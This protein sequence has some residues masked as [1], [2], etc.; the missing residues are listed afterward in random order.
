MS[1]EQKN[2]VRKT[3][4]AAAAVATITLFPAL[5]PKTDAV[6][7]R[8]RL[9]PYSR[10]AIR[11]LVNKCDARMENIL[12]TEEAFEKLK[13]LGRPAVPLLIEE[14]PLGQHPHSCAAEVIGKVGVN[15]AQMKK[16]IKMLDSDDPSERTGA[17]DALRALYEANPRDRRLTKAPQVLTQVLLY[18][19]VNE[20]GA[21]QEST[22]KAISAIG[23]GAVPAL[24][25]SLSE[26]DSEAEAA[27]NISTQRTVAKTLS[28]I[29]LSDDTLKTLALLLSNADTDVQTG[30]AF[31]IRAIYDANPKEPRLLSDMNLLVKAMLYAADSEYDRKGGA[32]DLKAV[33]SLGKPAIPALMTM[34]PDLR[35]PVSGLSA[36]AIGAIGLNDP[37]VSYL[38]TMLAGNVLAERAGAGRAFLELAKADPKNQAL[39]NLMPS[40]ARL[41]RLKNNSPLESMVMVANANPKHPRVLGSVPILVS[42]LGSSLDSASAAAEVLGE[43]KDPRVFPS[44][45]IALLRFAHNGDV[46]TLPLSLAKVDDRRVVGMLVNLIDA[47]AQRREAEAVTSRLTAAI[48]LGN[49]RRPEAMAPLVKLLGEADFRTR[50]MSVRALKALG[51]KSAL[52]A[53]KAVADKDVDSLVRLAALDA[54]KTLSK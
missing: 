50:L 41:L 49:T 23:K 16:L 42:T 45:S 14:V 40:F 8:S 26:I 12:V 32:D 15:D 39:L 25:K 34:L 13:R 21:A 27:V 35:E 53:L 43:I 7:A 11:D 22:I 37:Q 1:K 47:Y 51:Q 48:A 30:A 33:I 3:L 9:S 20:E 5:M 4:A 10:T 6:D 28:L 54:V 31:S 17:L 44:I 2:L 18:K 29:S 36:K 24:L 19:A 52:P 46:G 38:Y